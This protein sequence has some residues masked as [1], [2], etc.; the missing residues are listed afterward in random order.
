METDQAL[1]SMVL[2]LAESPWETTM[3]SFEGETLSCNDGLKILEM[4]RLWDFWQGEFEVWSRAGICVWEKLWGLQTAELEGKA[5]QALW[6]SEMTSLTLRTSR[7]SLLLD[8]ESV[9]LM[10]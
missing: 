4:I 10:L 3:L 6:N 2:V 8:F 5:T 1:F 7:Y 9:I